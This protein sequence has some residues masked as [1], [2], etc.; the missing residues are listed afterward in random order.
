M[1]RAKVIISAMLILISLVALSQS[2]ITN[3]EDFFKFKP[4]ADRML[5]D[6][7]KLIEYLNVVD[8]ESPR[9]K[10]L[11][12]G[13]SEMGKPLY[14]VL[15]SSE[16]NIENLDKLK[17]INKELAINYKLP[18]KTVDKYAGEGKV[19]LLAT[20][21]M[22]ADEVGPA[23]AAPLVVYKVAS[24]TDAELLSYLDNVVYM[25]VPSHN[26]DGMDMVVNNYLKNKGTRYE[27]TPFPGVYHKYV[28]HD[29]NRDFVTLS[30]SSTKAIN[31][32]YNDE[33]FP[34]VMVEKHQMGSRG[35]R[36]FVPPKHD[37]IAVNVDAELWTWDGIFGMGM[38]KDMTEQGLKGVVQGYAFDDYWPGSTETAH[39]KN[40][41]AMLTEAASVKVATPIYQEDN[42]FSVSGKGLSEYEK[43]SNFPDPWPGGWWKLSDILEYELSS[44][45]SLIKTA[46]LHKEEVLKLRN[47]LCVKEVAKG[48]TKPPYY[49]I[50]P[51][52]Q[53]DEGEFIRL[54]NLLLAHG[55][56]VYTLNKDINLDNTLYHNGDVVVPLAQPFRAFIKEVM[57]HQEFPVRHYTKGGA[58]IKPYDITSWSLPLHR[59]VNSVE[60]DKKYASVNEALTP[61]NGEF[62]CST[63]EVV[64]KYKYAIFPAESNDS[65]K[66]AFI[67]LNDGLKVWRT[68]AESVVNGL[69]ISKGSFIIGKSSKM[70]EV[71][72]EIDITPVFT[73][74][75]FD[76]EKSEVTMPRV[77]LV[78]TFMHDMDAGWT[79]FLFDSYNINYKVVHPGDFETTDFNSFDVVIFPDNNKDILKSGKYKSAD[80]V[81]SIPSYPPEYTKGIGDKGMN[82]L[83]NFFNDGG[84]IVAW[85][86]STGLFSG[87][88]SIPA[89]EKEK[90]IFRLPFNDISKDMSKK[91]LYCPGSFVSVNL[92]K[93]LELTQGMPGKIG[94]FYRGN[95]VFTT[96]VPTFVDMDR[97]VIAKFAKDDILLS[98]YAE[99]IKLVANKSAIVWL[100][101]NKG[102][103]VLFSFSPQFRASTPVA[104]KLLFNS[105]LLKKLE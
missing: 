75:D 73:E 76:V 15:L 61:V 7:E 87:N 78:E 100:K 27:G 83:L 68:T 18:D 57:E 40:M 24:T 34:Q 54:V 14:M 32:L 71:L 5:F 26:P 19:F 23:Q 95:P 2:G 89:G 102:Q 60:I 101:R 4:G 74:K 80:G 28:G 91:G 69:T 96:S 36:Y 30:Q 45:F 20:L 50:L 52:E 65:Y 8:K 86:R 12:I 70:K 44:T 81:Y 59:G 93:D 51:K 98:G 62:K 42:E 43:S 105:I 25:L 39:W 56:N 46:S 79:R 77:A 67:A 97:R 11:Q 29:I 3:P 13:E 6:Y 85:G 55:I 66:A 104:Y 41:I 9:V 22:H 90:D 38:Q 72:D 92:K 35:V 33:W 47:R 16:Q 17:A 48:E 53:H 58:I 99:N 103:M 63:G 31:R 82:N 21:S 88:L 10:M 1:N 84:V 64:D 37:P 49:Y 94:V